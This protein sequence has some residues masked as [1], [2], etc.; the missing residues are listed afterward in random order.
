MRRNLTRSMRDWMN[1]N[2]PMEHLL[3]DTL[4]TYVNSYVYMFG[5]L[6]LGSFVWLIVTGTILAIFGPEWWHVSPV[7]HFFNSMHFW[8]VQ[9]FFFFMVL[10]LWAQFMMAAWRGGR[11]WTWIGGWVLF[12]VSIVG[13]LTGYLS[14]NNFDSQWIGVQGKDAM[15]ATGI[16]GFFNLL[17]FGQMY[18]LHIFVIPFV[19]VM[20]LVVHILLVRKHGVVEP[21]PLEKGADVLHETDQ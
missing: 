15:N 10:H 16:G 17:N 13:G 1:D 6:T 3:P 8:G 20:L 2:I 4:P 12:L 11:H 7:G 18:G 5:I 14:Q 9:A 19:L 21:L